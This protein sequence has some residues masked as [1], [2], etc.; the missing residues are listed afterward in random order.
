MT[1]FPHDSAKRI[2]WVDS[3]CRR[4][5]NRTRLVNRLALE[6][7]HYICARHFHPIRFGIYLDLAFLKSCFF[8]LFPDPNEPPINHVPE[9]QEDDYVPLLIDG[10][11]NEKVQWNLDYDKVT[12]LVGDVDDEIDGE[13]VEYPEAYYSLYPSKEHQETPGHGEE[14]VTI[15]VD[16]EDYVYQEENCVPEGEVDVDVV[17]SDGS[18]IVAEGI[19]PADREEIVVTE[20]LE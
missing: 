4:K 12:S 17:N 20:N 10:F 1:P 3:M 7:R 14:D 6:G 19:P 2:M 5:G 13:V 11:D 16:G 9:P 18:E 8:F 15:I